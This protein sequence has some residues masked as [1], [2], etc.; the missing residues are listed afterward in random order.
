MDDY[1]LCRS[2][3]SLEHKEFIPNFLVT[4][5]YSW[6]SKQNFDIYNW[7]FL[8]YFHSHFE[9]DVCNKEFIF[10]KDFSACSK[11]NT[12]KISATVTQW[13]DITNKRVENRREE[14]QAFEVVIHK[15]LCS[16]FKKKKN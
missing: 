5:K 15:L 7:L 8:H 3:V 12:C 6:V 16:Q 11:L 13:N 10:R 14:I 4:L 9:T 1:I 2:S